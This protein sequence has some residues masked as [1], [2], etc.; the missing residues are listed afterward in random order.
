MKKSKNDY[1]KESLLLKEIE[2]L[3]R[4]ERF[5]KELIEKIE[6]CYG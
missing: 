4:I 6:E 3:E 1:P 2:K 5:S